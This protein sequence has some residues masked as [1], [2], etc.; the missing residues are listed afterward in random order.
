MLTYGIGPVFGAEAGNEG[1]AGPVSLASAARTTQSNGGERR[2]VYR[3]D[4]AEYGGGPVKEWLE[5]QGFKLK[6][7][8]TDPD[9]L[10]LSIQ[11]GALVL[12]ANGQIRGF[13]YKES[14][15]IENFSTA[16]LEWGMLKYPE[17]ASYERKV[18]NEGLMI[19]ISFGDEKIPSGNLILPDAPYFIGL[20]LCENDK[21]HTPYIGRYYLEGGRFVC[22]GHP[23]PNETIISEFDLVTAFRTY[24][25]K[26]EVPPISGI[27]LGV[28]TS[29]TGNGGKAAAYVKRIEFLE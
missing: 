21:L 16:R 5:S 14:L 12:K 28:D 29:D 15:Q 10:G 9:L 17:G 7:A 6:E 24:Y 22:L 11:D 23:K 27:N 4:F 26:N 18:R 25:E 20:Y 13:I 3:L 2:V 1:Q 19:Y 8:A